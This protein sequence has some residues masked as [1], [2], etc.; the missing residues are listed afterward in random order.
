MIHFSTHLE[1]QSN[2]CPIIDCNKTFT[3][4]SNLT[5]H[6]KRHVTIIIH[7][8]YALLTNTNIIERS[9]NILLPSN[10]TNE[11]NSVHEMNTANEINEMIAHKRDR[12]YTSDSFTSIN[13][14][15]DSFMIPTKTNISQDIFAD[16]IEYQMSIAN[17]SKEDIWSSSITMTGNITFK[18]EYPDNYLSSYLYDIYP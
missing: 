11:T 10:C 7:S 1:R 12:T 2:P 4:K 15:A 17:S 13:T 16:E 5:S 9:I 8:Q 14:S 18:L 3:I 6:L